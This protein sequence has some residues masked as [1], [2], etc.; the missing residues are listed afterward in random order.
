M[1]IDKSFSV[2]LPVQPV[3]AALTDLSRVARCLPGADLAEVDANGVHTGTVSV[4]LGPAAMSFQGLAQFEELDEAGRRLVVTASGSER[5]GR[6][7]VRAR[8]PVRLT[9]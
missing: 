6:G 5:R 9:D 8:I 2:E 7:T 4:R 3:W 1:E